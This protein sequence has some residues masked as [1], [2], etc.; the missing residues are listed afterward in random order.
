MAVAVAVASGVA[1]AVAGRKAVAVLC[2]WVAVGVGAA[3][4]VAGAQAAATP[5][6]I[7]MTSDNEI[8]FAMNRLLEAIFLKSPMGLIIH[9]FKPFANAAANGPAAACQSLACNKNASP[10]RV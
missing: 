7:T 10:I 4:P 5:S 6:S 1:V 3:G 9:P 2:T 8:F